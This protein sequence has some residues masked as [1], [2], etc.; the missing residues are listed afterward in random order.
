MIKK[1]IKTKQKV[2]NKF[3]FS[4]KWWQRNDVMCKRVTVS[5]IYIYI[6]RSKNFSHSAYEKSEAKMA[7]IDAQ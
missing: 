1:L 7:A 6:Y 4:L 2:V 3:D 5:S